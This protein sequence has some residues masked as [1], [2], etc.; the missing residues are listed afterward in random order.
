MP[1]YFLVGGSFTYAAKPGHGLD[2]TSDFSVIS[3]RTKDTKVRK[4][5]FLNFVIFASIAVKKIHSSLA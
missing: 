3:K 1:P 4:E 5:I 2:L